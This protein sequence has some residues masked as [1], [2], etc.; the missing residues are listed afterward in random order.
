MK[1]LFG[2]RVLVIYAGL[3]TASV[4]VTVLCG[5]VAVPEKSSFDEITVHR[6][7]VVEPDGTLRMVISDKARFPGLIVKGKE[8]PHERPTAGMLFFNDE[9]TENGGLI[10]GGYKDDNGKVEWWGHL[11]FDK[12][13]QDQALTLDA[14]GSDGKSSAGIKLV[15]RPDYPI[16]DL[17]KL[18]ERTKNLPEAQ[19]KAAMK[20][21]RSTHPAPEHRLAMRRL[22]NGAVKL[23]LNDSEGHSRIVL[24]VADDGTPS[25]RMLDAKGNVVGRVTPQ[26]QH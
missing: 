21:F 24:M 20:K 16:T 15:D 7:N 12:Y 25:I 8:Y 22:P 10:F 14:G 17:I 3:L 11:S 18:T 9:G 2:Q 6:I 19:R 1:P 23:N 26:S 5:F 13:M 4:V